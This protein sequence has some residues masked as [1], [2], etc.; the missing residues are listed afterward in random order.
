MAQPSAKRK[1]IDAND[2]EDRM[3]VTARAIVKTEPS[4]DDDSIHDG[5]YAY[6]LRGSSVNQEQDTPSHSEY[7]PNGKALPFKVDASGRVPP[8]RVPQAPT[9]LTVCLNVLDVYPS[10]H[11]LHLSAREEIIQ[12]AS[13]SSQDAQACINALQERRSGPEKLEPLIAAITEVVACQKAAALA[14]TITTAEALHKLLAAFVE[15]LPCALRSG[16]P[17]IFGTVANKQPPA[18]SL[19]LFP[20][21][22]ES[23]G[24]HGNEQSRTGRE[25]DHRQAIPRVTTNPHPTTSPLHQVTEGSTARQ[26][27]TPAVAS[28]SRS[29]APAKMQA[30]QL[31]HDLPPSR[32]IPFSPTN[33]KKGDM[34][35]AV[36][37]FSAINASFNITEA[38]LKR[39]C[40]LALGTKH[41]PTSLRPERLNSQLWAV[42][43]RSDEAAVLALKTNIMLRG[44]TFLPDPIQHEPPTIFVWRADE[45]LAIE[46]TAVKRRIHDVFGL[47]TTIDVTYRRVEKEAGGILVLFAN[48]HR[49]PQLYSF[50]LRLLPEARDTSRAVQAWFRP[51]RYC[52]PCEVCHAKHTPGTVCEKTDAVPMT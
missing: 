2:F 44:V 49:S 35:L 30:A 26:A 51:V 34:K 14:T 27:R 17:A 40:T 10:N 13:N 29:L 19:G 3:R 11:R 20:P 22:H 52:L 5:G 4:D 42:T 6:E 43:F 37:T 45:A 32:Q 1:A 9:Q 18:T 16:L 38:E 31:Q 46:P 7:Y 50:F 48:F 8:H 21:G 28:P 24:S 23:H 39:A 15:G 33:A 41:V 25:D 36:Y 47:S 12:Q